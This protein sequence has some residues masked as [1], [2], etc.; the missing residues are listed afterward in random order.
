MDIGH[1]VL[2]IFGL[3]IEMILEKLLL[4][5]YMVRDF[6]YGLVLMFLM[7]VYA[8]LMDLY[9]SYM[10]LVVQEKLYFMKRMEIN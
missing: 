7:D 9:R 10:I 2:G 8:R 1:L 4:W 6:L 3:I 5:V